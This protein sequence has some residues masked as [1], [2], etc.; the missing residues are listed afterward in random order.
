MLF[1]SNQ[2]VYARARRFGADG[3]EGMVADAGLDF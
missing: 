1:P 3:L 2:F